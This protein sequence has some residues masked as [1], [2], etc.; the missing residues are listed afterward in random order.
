MSNELPQNTHRLND[1]ALLEACDIPQDRYRVFI[2]DVADAF[3][4]TNIQGDFVFFNDALCR[5]FGH[6]REE[7]EGQNFRHF[8]DGANAEYAFDS[9][10]KMFETG[11]GVNNILWEISRKDGETR[12]IEI[13]ANL[14]Q[15]T[16]V[17]KVGFQG[18][19][20]DVTDKVKSE[21]ALKS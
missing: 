14:L 15:D 7:I 4:E 12:T 9:F 10:N 18:I 6:A 17:V 19:A 5:I 1:A 21:Q 2:Q 8:M 20:R 13:N 11:K 3:F 16:N